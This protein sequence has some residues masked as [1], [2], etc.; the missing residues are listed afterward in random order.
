MSERLSAAE[1][2][3][4]PAPFRLGDPVFDTRFPLDQYHRID[5]GP[6]RLDDISRLE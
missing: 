2:R 6:I 3:T 4:D 5:A 1:F